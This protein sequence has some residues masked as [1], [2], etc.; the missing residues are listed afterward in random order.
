MTEPLRLPRGD[1]EPVLVEAL[2]PRGFSQSRAALCARLFTE[3]SLDGVYSHGLNRF[4]Q[5]IGMVERGIVRPEREPSLVRSAGA[6]ETWD[7]QLGPGNLNAWASMG[8]AIERARECGVGVVA[9]RNTNHWMRGGSY[10]L[11]AAS[12][13]CIGICMTNTQPNMPPWGGRKASVGNNPLVIAA[14][15]EPYPIL[16][17]M[18][19]SQFSYGKMNVHRQRGEK[20][21]FP[22]GYNRDLQLTDDPGAILESEL[23]TPMGYWKGS[24][25]AILIDLLVAT[26][27]GGSTTAEIGERE[28]EYGIAQLFIAFH[29]DR[30]SESAETRRVLQAVTSSLRETPPLR[31]GESVSYPGERTWL[32]RQRNEREGIPIDPGIW[33]RILQTQG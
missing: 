3:A 23:A 33:E 18:A 11:R 14:P 9:L 2:L 27:S 19:M 10:G 4:P 12:S 29:L 26:L 20:L 7:G 25:L 31:E 28:E 16:L 24:G 17:D 5:F 15:N 1:I 22:G 8:R 13:G 21:P 6:V 30:V 32:R